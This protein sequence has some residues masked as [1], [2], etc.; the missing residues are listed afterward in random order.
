[1]LNWRSQQRATKKTPAEQDSTGEDHLDLARESLRE[2]LHDQRVPNVV[3]DA[4]A[5]DYEEVEAMLEKLEHGHLHIAVFGRVGVGKSSLLNALLGEQRFRTSPLHGETRRSEMVN[6]ETH[7]AGGV[8][9][10]DTPGVDEVDGETRERLALE[11]ASRADLVLFVVDSDIMDTDLHALRTLTQQRRP[12]IVVLNKADRYS[13]ADKSTLLA[14]LQDHLA[15]Y[16]DKVNIVCSAAQPAPQTIIA[17][18]ADGTET[19]RSRQPSIDVAEVKQRLWSILESEGKT[20]AALNASLFAGNLS[21]QIAERVMAARKSVAEK[22]VRT[23]CIAKG[24]AVALNPVPVAD[25]LAAAIVD[26]SMVV[27]LSKVYGIPLT[28]REATSLI[29]VTLA[30]MIALM[31]TVWAVNI[32]SSALKAGTGGLSTA[33]TGGAQGAVAYYSTYVV[34][35]VA[36][37]YIAQGKSWGE[38]GPKQV[39]RDILDSLNRESVMAQARHDILAQLKSSAKN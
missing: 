34:G 27:H 31:G 18:N 39:V 2:L 4:L 5:S 20:L 15:D 29:Q 16:I 17:I 30:Q 6:W 14:S 35:Q 7:D 24:I 37:R 9:L 23:Y 25:L 13:A 33:I 28:R 1:M 21:E 3:R 22:V 8:F 10:I 19:E 36:E 38:F 26:V 32:A 12:I 11:G